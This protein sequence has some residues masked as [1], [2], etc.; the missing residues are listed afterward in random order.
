MSSSAPPLGD[1]ALIPPGLPLEAA[2]AWV[3]HACWAELRLH[4]LLTRWLAHEPGD[5]AVA[6]LWSLRAGA[7]ERAAA[8]H[9][10]LPELREMPRRGFV[11]PSTHDVEAWF[12]ALARS[13]EEGDVDRSLA[14]E[15]VLDALHRGYEAHRLVAVGPADAPV[16]RA[17][18]DAIASL[19]RPPI[20]EP[21]HPHALPTGLVPPLP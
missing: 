3:G 4:E 9:Q 12:D 21:A 16:A 15:V 17:L 18:V 2:A 13:A 11:R 7:A 19:D 5:E 1:D 20:G 8:W 14:A 6:R 10:R